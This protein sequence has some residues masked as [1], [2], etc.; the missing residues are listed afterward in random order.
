MKVSIDYDKTVDFGKYRTFRFDPEIKSLK[1]NEVNKRRIVDAITY[2]LELK[3]LSRQMNAELIVDV[4]LKAQR[5][6]ENAATA[7]AQSYYGG[8]YRYRWGGG[9]TTDQIDEKEYTEGAV[10]VDIVDAIN[11]QLIWQG[12]GTQVLKGDLEN[13][14]SRINN[15][16]EKILKTYPPQ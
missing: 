8:Q 1:M 2:E 4:F 3:G 11:R 9:F 6:M 14:E 12:R 16:I 5:N 10:F 15:S 7:L 13:S